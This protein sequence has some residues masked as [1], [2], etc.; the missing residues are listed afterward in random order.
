MDK[1]GDRL[2][3]YE[4]AET[5]RKFMKGLHVYA[6]IDGRSFTKFTR[7]MQRP[8]DQMFT[9]VM[10][11]T[12]KTLVE[13]THATVAYTC[14]DEISLAWHVTDHNQELWFDGKIHKLTSVLASLATVAFVNEILQ[15]FDHGAQ[16]VNDLP[17]FDCR[18]FQVPHT[19]E[20]VNCFLW[21]QSDCVKNSVSQTAHAHFSHADLQN[22]HT[23]QKLLM[24]EQ[25]G[26]NWADLPES[27]KSGTFV[28]KQ[29]VSTEWDPQAWAAIPLQHRPDLGTMLMRNHVRE[30]HLPLISE[31]QN[32]AQVLFEHAEPH[33]KEV[34]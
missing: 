14:S 4:L 25:L 18:V 17:H 28:H 20:L 7:S 29:H 10:V 34:T 11:N 15:Q 22:K 30:F 24:L 31:I 12:T 21:R 3:T 1:L 26:V 33:I 32:P 27:V 8:F 16:L 19:A 5:G 13:H 23:Q 6:R 2:K 9:Q